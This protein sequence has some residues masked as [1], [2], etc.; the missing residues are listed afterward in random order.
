MIDKDILLAVIFCSLLVLLLIVVLVM[1]FFV[2][3][4]RQMKQEVELS[5]TRLNFERELR[6]VESEVSEQV[7]EYFASELHDNIGQLLTATHI[8]IEN[9][10]LDH[11]EQ[12]DGFKP[13]EI[14]L[15]EV[16]QQ[17]RLLSRTMNHDYLGN[18]GLQDAIQM[19]ADRLRKLKRF[20]I[21]LE[22]SSIVSGLEKNQE[23]M[24]FRIFQEIMQNALRHSGARNLF[25]KMNIQ[26]GF[27]LSVKDDGKGFDKEEILSSSRASGLRNIIKRA[28]LAGM[29]IEINTA[30]GQ[31]SLFILKKVST[32]T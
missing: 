2:S 17:L 6:Q 21:H 9:Q 11:P 12:A 29:D 15:E 23:L 16:T 22:L 1:V 31:G 26:Y 19:E 27:E 3:G 30:P 25:I 28:N 32:L 4:K 8:Q 20:E 24:L 10:K 5:L 18:I 13:I 14:Y 7:L